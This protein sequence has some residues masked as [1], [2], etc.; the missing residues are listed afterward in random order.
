MVPLPQPLDHVAVSYNGKLSLVVD[1]SNK[2][3]IYDSVIDK[4]SLG[5]NLPESHG[6]LTTNFINVFLYA[7]G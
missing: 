2:L 7:V 3:F 6:A 4:W 5:A 1:G